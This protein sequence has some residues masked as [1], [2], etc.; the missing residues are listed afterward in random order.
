MAIDLET[1]EGRKEYLTDKLED[2]LGGINDSYGVILMQELL[3][4]LEL[5]IKDFNDEVKVLCDQLVKKQEE[6]QHLMDM[7]VNDGPEN[8]KLI[9]NKKEHEDSSE[10]IIS[11]D[12]K[13]NISN[14]LVGNVTEPIFLPTGI[15]FLKIRDKRELKEFI[16]L[17][18]AKNQ[19]VNAEKTK[20][21]NLHSLSHYDKL[22]RSIAINYF[23]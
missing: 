5:T 17:E 10:N 16:D 19:L 9:N 6:R 15:L 18:D 8:F 14:T 11:E 23:E 22:K 13:S 20:I 1:T 21:L 4:R 7:L 2:L 12:F 3:D